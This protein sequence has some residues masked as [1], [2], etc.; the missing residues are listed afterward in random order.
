MDVDARE[1]I[2][3][4]K[5]RAFND[6][7]YF[8]DVSKLS[9]LGWTERMSW[10]EGL[11]SFEFISHYFVLKSHQYVEANNRMVPRKQRRYLLGRLVCRTSTAPNL[12]RSRITQ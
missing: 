11:V 7:R 3:Q 12:D 8:V 9:A 1:N 2:I 6:R 10:L 4:V 5:D